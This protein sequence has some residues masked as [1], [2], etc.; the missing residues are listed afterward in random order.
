M[1]PSTSSERVSGVTTQNAESG[2]SRS[3]LRQA[4][5]RAAL[6]R[7]IRI[8]VFDLIV[9]ALFSFLS[10]WTAVF[11]SGQQ[12]SDHLWT[13]TN[14]LYFGDQAQYLGWIRTSYHDIL[15]GNPFQVSGGTRDYLN[16]GLAI[17]EILVN[18]GMS[19]WLSYLLWCPVAAI[20]LALAVRAYVGRILR[21][22]ASRRAALV[23][24]LFYLSPLQYIAPRLHWNQSFFFQSYGLEM[25]P[26]NYLWGYPFTALTIA[27][28][29]ATLL[30]YERARVEQRIRPSAPI[31]AL[32]CA[33]F[34]PWQGATLILILLGCELY[35]LVVDKKRIQ[36]PLLL[37]TGFSAALPLL[38][39]FL[40]AR[41]DPTW[42]LSGQVNQQAVL[43]FGDLFLAMVPLL[44]A[45]IL[46][47]LKRPHS[48]PAITVRAWPISALAVLFTVYFTHIGTFPK[49][50][51]Q[52]MS[53]P[54]AILAV[55]GVRGL[56]R[57]A[58][59][60]RWITVG[61]V[62]VAALIVIPVENQLDQVRSLGASPTI[63]GSQP[64]FIRS[65]EQDALNYLATK[66][67]PG[68]V[69]STVYLG[70][71]V[72]A[73]TGRNTWVGIASWTPDYAERVTQAQQLFAGELSPAKAAALVRSTQAR[74]LLA[75][76]SHPKNLSPILGTTIQA[77]TSFGCATVYELTAPTASTKR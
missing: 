30:Q 70:Q 62:V 61:C 4:R 41:L 49:H 76:C 17:S 34:Q 10:L 42:R 52:G 72:P 14:G 7:V 45:A 77:K 24:A 19:T 47:Y 28:L 25:W 9:I 1:A 23:L 59:S 18:L 44:L 68:S 74:F 51:L 15:I 67:T 5:L 29:L 26:I 57:S 32:L 13:G 12:S 11:L 2:A 55:C 66:P 75:D 46:A 58:P 50:A 36:W 38:Y 65:S 53:I 63:F 21:T 20:L 3:D 64:Y 35:T 48:F 40:L 56:F 27:L 16:P 43:P 31:L 22:T 8:D 71:I 60:W 73:E 33:W 39:Y 37:A 6:S 54:L 69:L